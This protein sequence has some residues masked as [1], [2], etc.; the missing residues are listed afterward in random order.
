MAPKKTVSLIRVADKAVLVGI[1]ENNMAV[2]TE[3]GPEQ[4]AALVASRPEPEPDEGF[5]NVLKAASEKLRLVGLKRK[6]TALES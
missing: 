4:T 2:L 3:L 1:T 5:S 6:Q